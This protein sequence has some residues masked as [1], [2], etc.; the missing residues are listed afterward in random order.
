MSPADKNTPVPGT[1]AFQLIRFLN[2]NPSLCAG[3]EYFEDLIEPVIEPSPK[4]ARKGGLDFVYSSQV[5][6]GPGIPSYAPVFPYGKHTS[7]N[8]VPLEELVIRS[9]D[10]AASSTRFDQRVNDILNNLTTP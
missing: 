8:R 2:D 5:D 6:Q 3:S 4:E 9:V 7:I 10:R 1:I